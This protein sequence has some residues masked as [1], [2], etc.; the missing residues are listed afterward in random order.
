MSPTA[1]GTP[2]IR[3]VLGRSAE[4]MVGARAEVG[5][6]CPGSAVGRDAGSVRRGR[7]GE[8]RSAAALPTRPA[9]LGAAAAGKESGSSPLPTHHP[10]QTVPVPDGTLV[11]PAV[12]AGW[13]EMK[14][15]CSS[16]G[17]PWARL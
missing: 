6:V 14:P 8:G 11:P 10:Q 4:G 9:G 17:H 13:R 3:R 2:K 7:A 15:S 12:V 16:H 5:A 1:A